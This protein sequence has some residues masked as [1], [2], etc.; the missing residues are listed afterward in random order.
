MTPEALRF[1]GRFG[2]RLVTV[3]QRLFSYRKFFFL[4][5]YV[6]FIAFRS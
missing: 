3:P 6:T 2:E 5:V 1:V 4:D